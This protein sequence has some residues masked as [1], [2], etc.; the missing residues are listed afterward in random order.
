MPDDAA[1]VMGLRRPGVLVVGM[2]RSGT[3]AVA[4]VRHRLGLDTGDPAD[5]LPGDWSNP[6]G[7]WESRR[8]LAFNERLLSAMGAKWDGV[9]TKLTLPAGGEWMEAARRA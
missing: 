2:H 3:S 4:G 5:A 6:D 7:H 1:P 9:P 8:L